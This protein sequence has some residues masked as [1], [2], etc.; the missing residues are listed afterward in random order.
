MAGGLPAETFDEILADDREIQKARAAEEAQEATANA[1]PHD[2]AQVDL[3]EAISAEKRSAALDEA[4]WEFD[5]ELPASEGHRL[6]NPA[7]GYH[8]SVHALYP[9]ALDEAA[10]IE[11]QRKKANAGDGPAVP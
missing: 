8:T 3:E 6:V 9:D 7:A 5:E 10:R 1:Q 11:E 4:G 2:P